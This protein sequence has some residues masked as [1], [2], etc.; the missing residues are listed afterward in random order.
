MAFRGNGQLQLVTLD[1]IWIMARTIFGEAR[2]EDD[3]GRLAVANVILNR[4]AKGFRNSI[5]GVC[6]QH[7]A[8]SCWLENDPNR[9][10]LDSIGISANSAIRECFVIGLNALN[11]N[12]DITF[13]S[14]HYFNP[15]L[16]AP[17]WAAGHTQVFSHGRHI[18][19]NDIK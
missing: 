1:D 17:R 9:P 7:A 10:V 3:I 2:G 5:A 16:A 6:L 8:F 12:D 13:G 19:F 18:F 11:T 14:T 4:W 15:K